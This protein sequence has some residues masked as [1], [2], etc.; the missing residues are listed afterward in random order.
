MERALLNAKLV[1]VG[2]TVC[3]ED[4]DGSHMR[5]VKTVEHIE[6]NANGCPATVVILGTNDVP[7]IREGDD[8][9]WIR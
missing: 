1:T 7:I 9:L 5:T 2:M 3:A 8:L 4:P 6:I